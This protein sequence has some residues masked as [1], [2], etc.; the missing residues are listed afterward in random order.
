M[1]IQLEEL[2][3]LYLHSELSLHSVRT[4]T[5]RPGTSLQQHL[6]PYP[7][8]VFPLRGHARFAFDEQ[9]HQLDP[10]HVFHLYGAELSDRLIHCDIPEDATLE[11]L[12]LYYEAPEL[13]QYEETKFQWNFVLHIGSSPKLQTL[14]SLLREEWTVDSPLSRLRCKA[15]FY[16]LLCDIFSSADAL[17]SRCESDRVNSIQA[18]LKSGFDEK[19]TVQ[20]LCERFKISQSHLFYLFSRYVGVSPME[21][22]ISLR[23]EQAMGLIRSTSLSIG[24]IAA[25]VGYADPQYFSRQFKKRTGKSPTE[26]RCRG[27]SS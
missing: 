8:F 9:D 24:E 19:I 25:A 14:L 26:V 10:A 21:Y 27:S 16:C 4:F 22:L 6:D 2:I 12:C 17:E 3:R 7:V 15:A 18:F 23:M 20:T 11:V 13:A 1:A 5:L